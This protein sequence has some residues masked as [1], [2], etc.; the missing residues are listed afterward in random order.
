MST[1]KEGKEEGINNTL[2]KPYGKI[3]LFFL[4]L[5][6]TCISIYE[7]TFLFNEVMLLGL[8]M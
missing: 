5:H 3:F 1:P 2:E 8:A 4:I 7:Y 6:M